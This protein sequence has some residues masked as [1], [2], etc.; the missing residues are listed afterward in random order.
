MT[1]ATYYATATGRVY[2]DDM[3]CTGLNAW[4]TA[5]NTGPDVR[6]PTVT[7][8]EIDDRRLRPCGTC[9]PAPPPLRLVPPL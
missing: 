3:V 1:A 5:H 9:R 7:V 6:P 4:W 2:H 8:R